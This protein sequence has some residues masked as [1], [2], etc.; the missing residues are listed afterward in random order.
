MRVD[1][2]Q[3]FWQYQPV[4][5]QWISN[6]MQVLQRDFG[7]DALLPQ[8][9]KAGIE[10]SI[11]VQAD[12]T[13][14]ETDYLLTLADQHDFIKAV[15]GWTDLKSPDAEQ[16]IVHHK[17]SP[18]LAGFRSIMQGAPDHAYLAHAL[19]VQNL[20]LLSKY[21]LS[22]DLLVYHHQ[23]GSLLKCIEKLPDNRLMLDH[24]GKPDIKNGQIKEW[25]KNMKTLA[26]HPGLYCKLSGMITEADH[27]SWTHE[28]LLPYLETAAEC[29]GTDRICFGSDWPVCLLA[30]S[31][32]QVVEV[33]DRFAQQVSLQERE[34][35]FGLN[36]LKFYTP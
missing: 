2:H 15:V 33:A 7:P 31:Y 19:F 17:Q 24:I 10:G 35:L 6:E 34:K 12:E 11:A 26:E 29:F 18:K 9:Q 20:Q 30:G 8:L 27:N 22:F 13:T 1:A 25:K 3:H 32:A 4:K 21:N 16:R 36:A 14:A 5:H 23:M 28:A